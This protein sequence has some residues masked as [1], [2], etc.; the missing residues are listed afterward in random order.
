MSFAFIHTTPQPQPQVSAVGKYCYVVP[1]EDELDFGDQAVVAG[2][3]V[4]G[5]DQGSR[6]RKEFTITN[7]SVVP[8][9]FNVSGGVLLLR[10]SFLNGTKYNTRVGEIFVWCFILSLVN[11]FVAWFHTLQQKFI[12]IQQASSRKR[13]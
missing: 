12:R 4:S 1:S 5:S 10:V 13:A 11:I 7:Q 2:G 9:A 8:A 6:P 3:G